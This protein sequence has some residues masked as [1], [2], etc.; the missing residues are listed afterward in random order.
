MAV[1]Q[2]IEAD[3]A[4]PSLKGYSVDKCHVQGVESIT[5]RTAQQGRE[6]HINIGSLY[7]PMQKPK[8]PW[9]IY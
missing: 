8:A 1:A 2:A 9:L 5:N 7:W 6:W 4:G 3:S